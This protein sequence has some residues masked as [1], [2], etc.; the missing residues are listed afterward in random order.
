MPDVPIMRVTA[1]RTA[2]NIVGLRRELPHL[3]REQNFEELVVIRITHPV[4]SPSRTLP[5]RQADFIVAT[6]DG[7]ARMMAQPEQ[8]ITRLQPDVIHELLIKRRI[9]RASEL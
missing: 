5:P 8:I 4:G 1:I 2:G 6:P 7:D 9:C 3:F